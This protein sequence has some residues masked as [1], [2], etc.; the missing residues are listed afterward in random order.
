MFMR[1]ISRAISLF[2][3]LVSVSTA[4][5]Q[6]GAVKPHAGM[7]RYPDVSS[8]HIV[9]LYANDLWVAPRDG[10]VASPLASPPGQEMM[11]RFSPDGKT[12]AFQGNYDGGRDI[13]TVGVDGGIPNRV[14][15]H[16]ASEFL[17]DWTPDGKLIF[18]TSGRSLNVKVAELFTVAAKGGY[19][20]R[21][22]VPYGTNASL[23][24][25][26]R[27]LAYT[28]HSTDF[29]T[30]KRYRGG[31]ATDIWLF[32]LRDKKSKRMTDFEGTDSLPMWNGAK[33]YY[34]SDEG[35]SHR[36]NIWMYDTTNGR[37]QQITRFDQFDVKWPAIGPGPAGKGEI[38]YQYG[39][40]LQLLDLATG[41]SR[42]VE[43]RIPGARANLRPR[44]VDVSRFTQNWAVSPT[45][46]RA[47]IEARGDIWTAPAKEGSPRNLTRT[48]GVAER[49]PAWS[50]D[51]RYVAYFSDASGEYE[52]YL[53]PADGKGE[54]R[55]LTS[56]GS[57]F[58]YS[59]FW[60]PDS[61]HIVFSDKTGAFFLHNIAT[62]QNK[63]IDRD[64][65]QFNIRVNWSHDSRWIAYSRSDARSRMSAVWIYDVEKGEK[66]QATRG[67]FDDNTPTFDRNGD[68]L[69]YATT[70]AFQPTYADEDTTW[71]YNNSQVLIAVPLRAD[72]QS[73]FAPES[74]EEPIKDSAAPKTE[75]IVLNP[76]TAPSSLPTA[77]QDD[78][79]SG[80]WSGTGAADFLPGGSIT[81]K[82]T[83]R[84]S[85][86]SVTG[87]LETP[88]GGGAVTGSYDAAS[89]KL[90]MSASIEGGPTVSFNAVISGN[91]MTGTGTAEGMTVQIRLQRAGAAPQQPGEPAKPGDK[92][93]DSG[94]ARARVNIDFEGFEQRGI[95]LPIRRGRFG[96]MGVNSR[97]QLIFVRF[98]APGSEEATTIKLFD[99]KDEKREEKNVGAGSN[100]EMT[101]D[102]T[103]L[104]I[105]RGQAAVIQ[106]ASA[107]STSQSVVT[108]P[109][110]AMIDP[111]QE[112]RQMF[113]EAW[114]IERDFFYDPTMHGVDWKAV[115]DQYARMLPD[116]ASREDLSYI[117]S[118]MISELNVGHAYYSGG[119][120]ESQPSV[121]AG[122]LGA[123]LEL[124]N[125]A[126]R[127][128]NIYQGGP[129]DSDA[130][131]PLSQPGVNVKEGDY[132]LAVNG[133]PI[134]TTRDPMAAFQG[135]GGQTV[136]LTVSPSPS[137]QGSRD[138][139]LKLLAGG[140][141]NLRFREWI[142]KNRS[143]VEKA[144][145][146]KVGYVYVPSTGLDGQSELYRQLLGQRGKDALII[147]ERWNS[148]GQ[149]PTRFIELLNRPITNY[150]ARRDHADWAWP[151]D[152]HQGPKVMLIN[153][154]AGS[155]GDAF[156]WYFRQ[157]GLGKLI[158][159]RTWGGLVGISGNP[160]L[161]DGGSVTAP[162]FAFY[163]KDSTW[164]VEGHGVDPDIEVIDDP[165]LMQNGA[166]PQL[167]AA[168]KHI[169]EELKR[170]PYV[171]ARRPAYPNRKGFGLDPRDR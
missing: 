120:T 47:A 154:L 136:T 99:L 22:P 89:K 102:G 85:G 38:V 52:L 7:L 58:R 1:C 59:P 130:R 5:A 167:D 140:D 19:P 49:D 48:S 93:A 104:L 127:I 74:D 115:R 134:D 9:F 147:D 160:G 100:F 80:V 43:V 149:I 2:A 95:Q 34:L 117:I 57:A 78:E 162:T 98:G 133:A 73:P 110:T 17:C 163:E 51:G 139:V 35:P 20:S 45:G 86:N 64:P 37:R 36:E 13:Y 87:S 107:G 6:E 90:T 68:W 159:T 109:M 168:I 44:A 106:D 97:G 166:D 129:W 141:S 143:Y 25:D 63:E 33:V 146:G 60:S 135:L 18:S 126:Y 92:P 125:G 164:G 50:P 161:I 96:Q 23:S 39:S 4:Q 118:E 121:G 105:P 116:V 150:W 14:T 41:K 21:L 132:L 11:P 31:M 108:T 114:R 70:R 32:D 75:S 137:A 29:R 10:G 158:G 28:P 12:I 71:I 88:I 67:M 42:A 72:I 66:R 103:K 138:V 69:Y 155:G 53:H 152:A 145:D 30:W 40:S 77:A 84:R 122:L 171:P 101:A 131:G 151:W 169:Q 142:E 61:K 153:G 82:L 91:V 156:P 62:G 79:V 81:I 54:P 111:D 55:K 65:N 119:D 8:T 76:P 128:S 56:G 27:W 148:G 16:P 165:A 123:D 46:K 144:T 113:N 170:N 83:L 112:W 24:S 15:Y 94:K 124:V 157:A 3:V 26:G